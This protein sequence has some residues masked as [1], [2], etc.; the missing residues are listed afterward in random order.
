MKY[1]QLYFVV[2]INTMLIPIVDLWEALNSVELRENYQ[3]YRRLICHYCSMMILT[4]NV[5]VLSVQLFV[6]PQQHNY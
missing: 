3:L 2:E 1:F 4:T 6:D 5:S